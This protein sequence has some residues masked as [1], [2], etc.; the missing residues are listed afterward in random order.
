M[1]ERN[2]LAQNEE[3][4]FVKDYKMFCL[5]ELFRAINWGQLSGRQLLGGQLS[6]GQLSRHQLSGGNFSGDNYPGGQL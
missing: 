2:V 5:K 4:F 3:T 6:W 1:H